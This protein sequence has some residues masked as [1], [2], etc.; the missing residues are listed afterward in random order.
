MPE[1]QTNDVFEF[2]LADYGDN[3][4]ITTFDELQKWNEKERAAWQWVNNG[5]S[6]QMDGVSTQHNNFHARVSQYVNEWR[7]HQKNPQQLAQVLNQLSGVFQ[8]C[9]CKRLIFHSTAPE[10][11]FIFSLKEKHGNEVA[12][13]AY[14]TLL[15]CRLQGSGPNN[16][17]FM[18]GMIEGFL[19]KREIDWVASAH[20]EVLNRRKNQYAGNISQQDTR[21]KEIEGA[22]ATLNS[23]FDVALNGKT[24]ALEKLHGDQS[25]E[26]GKLI[27]KHEDNPVQSH[28]AGLSRW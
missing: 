18:E 15:G 24:G 12:G 28:N 11:A 1:E 23:A 26:F 7:D 16:A 19:Y 5:N 4:R 9:Y 2:D 22:N 8:D 13:G 3:V 6:P 10:A 21:F 14:A 25:G 17:K 27:K 20:Q